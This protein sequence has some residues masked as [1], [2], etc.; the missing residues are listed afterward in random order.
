[1]FDARSFCRLGGIPALADL[2]FGFSGDRRLHVIQA[3]RIPEG[4][5]QRCDIFQVCLYQ[6]STQRLERC[7]LFAFRFAR[8]PDNPPTLTQQVP[9]YLPAL[10]PR[11]SDHNNCLAF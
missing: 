2:Y 8:Q 11:C 4:S 9:C 5:L 10:S 6:L 1:M 7:G 3:I